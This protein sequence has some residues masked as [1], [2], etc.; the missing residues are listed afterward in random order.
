[1]Y[2]GL[3]CA[4][5]N[6]L[7]AAAAYGYQPGLVLMPDP[8]DPLHAA[9]IDLA[10]AR[11]TPSELFE[12]IPRRHTNR[13]AYDI[14]RGMPPDLLQKLESLGSHSPQVKVFWFNDPASRGAFED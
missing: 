8:N 11:P 4:I 9:R 3:G 14:A 12:A 7:I 1:M 13:G 2:I 5:E 10:P 6:L